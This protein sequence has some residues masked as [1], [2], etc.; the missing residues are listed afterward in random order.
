MILELTAT[1]RERMIAALQEQARRFTAEADMLEAE[2][3]HLDA[4]ADGFERRV[5]R[6]TTCRRP[7][8][9]APRRREHRGRSHATRG[10]PDDP[11]PS[12]DPPG[13]LS[14]RRGRVADSGTF[15]RWWD[16]L[17]APSW[18]RC[19]LFL[20][21]PECV[22]RVAW[23]QLSARIAEQRRVELAAASDPDGLEHVGAVLGW[24][25]E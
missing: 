14:Q 3:R 12:D 5:R 20:H 18:V 6:M 4:V 8:R 10:P 23:R 19:W 1:D 17:P 13:R 22:Q 24:W 2:A 15:F 25:F 7:T 11:D 9:G 16:L 21:L